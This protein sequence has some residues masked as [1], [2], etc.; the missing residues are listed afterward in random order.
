MKIKQKTATRI[1]TTVNLV[2][3]VENVCYR[4]T[5]IVSERPNSKPYVYEIHFMDK[6]EV[7]LK[8]SLK[9]KIR[10]FIKSE[11]EV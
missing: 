4:F 11:L 5:A 2:V 6:Y 1:E 3:E 9:K 7:P 8:N 10:N